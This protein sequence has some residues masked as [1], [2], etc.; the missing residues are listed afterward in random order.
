MSEPNDTFRLVTGTPPPDQ[1]SDE[2]LA[3]FYQAVD[4]H[5]G[6]AW[7]NAPLIVDP[8]DRDEAVARYGQY[9][10]VS[11]YLMITL[12]DLFVPEPS[13]RALLAA[14]LSQVILVEQ[15]DYEVVWGGKRSLLVYVRGTIPTGNP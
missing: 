14:R 11:A 15:I 4:R 3:G 9:G 2:V 5:R 1:A 8:L 12:D 10:H 13:V 6:E 7:D